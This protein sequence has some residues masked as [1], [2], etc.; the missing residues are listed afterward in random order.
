[1]K[2]EIAPIAKK[3]VCPIDDIVE[4]ELCAPDVSLGQLPFV[5]IYVNVQ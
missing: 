3:D 1:M 4:L 5:N 2:A